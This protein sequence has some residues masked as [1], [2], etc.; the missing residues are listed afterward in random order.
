M[1]KMIILGCLVLFLA[2]MVWAQEKVEA[3]VWNVGDRWIYKNNDGYTWSIEVVD[4]EDNFYITNV[5]GRRE[6]FVFDKSTLNERFFIEPGVGGRRK[7]ST[8]TL[9][10]LFD[11]PIFVGKEWIDTTEAIPHSGYKKVTYK[12]EYKIEGTEEVSTPI[13]TFTAF[14]ILYT[15]TNMKSMRSG[16]KRFWYSPEVKSWIKQEVEKTKYWSYQ[17][18]DAELISYKLK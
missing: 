3:P 8:G 1:Q 17:A 15:Q 4:A 6:L 2:P 12:C 14:K 18:Q 10:K 13:G 16:W 9:R 11:F 5:E 7:E